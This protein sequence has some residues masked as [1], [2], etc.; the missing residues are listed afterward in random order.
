MFGHELTICFSELFLK[1]MQPVK[2]KR[3]TLLLKK[4][5]ILNPFSNKRGNVEFN[6][7]S[8]GK[9]NRLTRKLQAV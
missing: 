1:L 6:G 3:V 4:L 2:F 7:E 5:I 9:S 8:S